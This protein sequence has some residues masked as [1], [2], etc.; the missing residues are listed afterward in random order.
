MNEKLLARK[1]EF[2]K[3]FD[4]KRPWYSQVKAFCAKYKDY[5]FESRKAKLAEVLAKT[6]DSVPKS[7]TE[8]ASV[9]K[10]LRNRYPVKH[11]LDVELPM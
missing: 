9:I 2:I 1:T 5:S 10:A 7:I 8:L 11:P 4:K 6:C 3:T